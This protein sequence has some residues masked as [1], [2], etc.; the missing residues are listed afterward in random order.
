MSIFCSQVAKTD[1][2]A[3]E[4]AKEESGKRGTING[5]PVKQEE[6]KLNKQRATLGALLSD[7]VDYN[8]DK[9]LNHPR[10]N[11][12]GWCEERADT[13]SEIPNGEG[14]KKLVSPEGT[15]VSQLMPDASGDAHLPNS[16]CVSD[17]QLESKLT[18]FRKEM[19]KQRRKCQSRA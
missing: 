2:L 13:Y 6:T 7:V 19:E 14:N 10:S 18:D 3:Q 12:S 1:N 9:M 4:D 16:V 8:K 15:F 5:I 17:F 11:N